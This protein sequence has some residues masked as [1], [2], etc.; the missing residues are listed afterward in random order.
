MKKV[1]TTTWTR[2]AKKAEM[3]FEAVIRVPSEGCY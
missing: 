3:G 2:I 1:I